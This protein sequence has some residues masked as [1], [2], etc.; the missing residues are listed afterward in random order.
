M[1]SFDIPYLF[2][3]G[4]PV[5]V[6][7]NF[8][9]LNMDQ[10]F[11]L[12]TGRAQSGPKKY[13]LTSEISDPNRTY[14]LELPHPDE[15]VFPER[16]LQPP[17]ISTATKILAAKLTYSANSARE[18][19]FNILNHFSNF[20][21][22]L[23]MKNDPDK[24]ALEHFLFSR[25]EGH[26]ECFASDMVILLRAA[27][28][29]ARLVNGF[30]GAEWHEWGNHLIVRQSHAHSW[31]EAYLAGVTWAV[32]DRTPPDASASSCPATQPPE[33]SPRP[34]TDELAAL[35]HPLFRQPSSR[36]DPVLPLRWTRCYGLA[37]KSD[38]IGMERVDIESKM[39]V[40]DPA[41][42]GWLYFS[43]KKK[44]VFTAIIASGIVV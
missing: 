33:T 15:T 4:I 41:G 27:G 39:D 25:K 26:S 13:R 21:Y 5:F 20:A 8:T 12:K 37:E 28:V 43:F 18:K 30:V 9:R 1:E 16:F 40:I 11:V 29:P 19:A 3:H 42:N 44:W 32:F 31:V 22:T 24:T 6:D 38:F 34:P 7:G 36:H 14:N 23:E 17:K 35:Y 10:G 2:T